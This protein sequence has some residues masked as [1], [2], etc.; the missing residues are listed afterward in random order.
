MKAL[1]KKINLFPDETR[2]QDVL[3]L[4]GIFV[5]VSLLI[6]GLFPGKNVL[7]VQS[8]QFFIYAVMTVP[9]VA[10]LYF[11]IMSLRRNLY[12]NA[13]RI[14]SSIQYKM[15][16]AFVFVAVLPSLPV[17][18][19]SNFILNQTLSGLILDNTSKALND[20]ITISN[21]PVANMEYNMRGELQAM[22]YQ[23]D[24]G[25]LTAAS[26]EGRDYLRN[27]YAIKGMTA[28]VYTFYSGDGANALWLVDNA[29]D[30]IRTEI[31]EFYSIARYKD[32]SR[33]DR[34]S[35][36]GRD[37]I[38]GSL[39][40]NNNLVVIARL[41]P[42]AIAK[43][44][45]NFTL[46][47]ADHKRLATTISGLKSDGGLYLFVL[48]LFIILVSVLLSLYLS[49]SITR[50]VIELSDATK[51]LAKGNFNVSLYRESEDELTVLFKSFNRMVYELNRNRK[52]V[53]QKQRLEAW[54]EMARQ[55]VHEIK[56]PLTPIQLS[57]ERIH[58]RYLE[59]HP[60]I[61]NII[62][63]GTE[64]IV[65]EV[66]V[67]KNILSEFTEFARLPE[68]K[69]VRT[70]INTVL[71]NCVNFFSGHE[72]VTFH[73]EIDRKIPEIYID[74]ML[75]KQTL[76]NLIQNAIDAI[77]ESGN[78]YVS[79]RLLT[80]SG[81]SSVRITIRDD[82]TGIREFDKD[83]IFNPGFSTKSSGTGLGL[84]IVEKIIMEHR[85]DISCMSE[86]GKGTEFIID[87]PVDAPE[88][89]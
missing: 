24:N 21:E 57:A 37:F 89:M 35:I 4:V 78:I 2:V 67:L 12:T 44:S 5:F 6:I 31:T 9:V 47:L 74:K 60:D 52:V 27:I 63:S 23:M 82:G 26:P 7:I 71:E 51:E 43:S 77:G 53:Y 3:F 41:I 65:E 15:A 87:L 69:P 58:K 45:E 28:M 22:K 76:N 88:G 55:V 54:R 36:K 29:P 38:A 56:N 85:G 75:M 18:L 49:K 16:I 34:L 14:G 81:V 50:P 1:L 83:K 32:N 48:M 19:M 73:T 70:D 64:T 72:N 84:A 42:E 20:A 40:Y 8:Q 10:A 30:D 80:A 66:N 46:A 62:L 61:R 17:V 11:I 86:Y 68:M 13:A 59:N 79:S 25:T 39:I 33:I